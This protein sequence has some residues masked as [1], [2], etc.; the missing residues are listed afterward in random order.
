MKTIR[1]ICVLSVLL[2]AGC[3]SQGPGETL[4]EMRKKLCDT[5]SPAVMLEYTAPESQPLVAMVSQMAE[6]PKKGP[7]I[8]RRMAAQCVTELKVEKVDVDGDR[9]V[10]FVQGDAEPTKMRK[11]DG[12]WKMVIDKN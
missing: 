8:K 1:S 3:G 10:V 6:D 7:D 9:A 11:I 5:N 12:K 4:L 2:L